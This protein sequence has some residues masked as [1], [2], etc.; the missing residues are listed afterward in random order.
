[1]NRE[2]AKGPRTNVHQPR[3]MGGGGSPLPS[4][5]KHLNDVIGDYDA[6]HF[7]GSLKPTWSNLIR[8]PVPASPAVPS[9]VFWLQEYS[10]RSNLNRRSSSGKGQVM[11]LK[12]ALSAA[13]SEAPAFC[14]RGGVSAS[15]SAQ[16]KKGS[17]GLHETDC[18]LFS[19]G[20]SVRC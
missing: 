10:L 13:A 14:C 17:Q 16:V 15:G 11:L 2:G 8:D 3:R 7:P 9:N 1:M 5:L 20:Y 4:H 12:A 6:V 18:P 19:Q